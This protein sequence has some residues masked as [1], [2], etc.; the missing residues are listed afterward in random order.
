MKTMTD[1]QYQALIR[2]NTEI[3]KLIE[4]MGPS[5]GTRVSNFCDQTIATLEQVDTT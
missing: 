4:Y 2:N 5:V 3:R 1:K